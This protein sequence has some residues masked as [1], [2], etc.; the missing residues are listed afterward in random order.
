MHENHT[1]LLTF[2][3]RAEARAF[4]QEFNPEL[5]EDGL[6]ELKTPYSGLKT[7]LLIT[8]EGAEESMSNLAY[9]LGRYPKIDSIINYGVC[10]LLRTDSSFQVNELYEV[11][12]VYAD[13]LNPY[14]KFKSFTLS[15]NPKALELITTSER[16]LDREKADRLDQFAPLVDRELWSLAYCAQKRNIP[17]SSFK[18]ISDHADGEIC[19]QVKEDSPFWSDCLLRHFIKYCESPS[20]EREETINLFKDFIA[21]AEVYFHITLS[22]ERSLERLIHALTLKGYEF[23][24]MKDQVK[25]DDLILEKIRPKEKTKKLILGLT[26]LLNPLDIKIKKKLKAVTL[27]LEKLQVQVKHEPD[28]DKERLHLSTSLST[29]EDFQNLGH[30]LLNCPFARWTS[31]LRGEDHV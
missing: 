25:F 11:R 19:Q 10:G 21:E 7:L 3:H 15:S 24:F 2:A 1:I 8:G 27:P 22:Q 14:P 20:P 16:V 29:E 17:L 13:T 28:Y 30:A 4:L 12:T 18:V 9:I 31:I 5:K 6:Y 23:E 26:E